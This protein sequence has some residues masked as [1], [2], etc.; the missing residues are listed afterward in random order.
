VC[1]LYL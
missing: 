1:H